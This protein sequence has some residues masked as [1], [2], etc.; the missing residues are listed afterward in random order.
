LPVRIGIVIAKKTC[1][2]AVQ[3]NKIRRQLRAICLGFLSQLKGGRDFMITVTT[4]EGN[5]DFE[6]FRQDLSA[7]FLKAE[8]VYGDQ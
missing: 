3:R 4:L 5:P 1:R 7:L 8:A 2:L 6:D